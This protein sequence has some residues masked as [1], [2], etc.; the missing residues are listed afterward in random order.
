MILFAAGTLY[1]NNTD[2]DIAD[3]SQHPSVL[4]YL[5]FAAAVVVLP[6]VIG[7]GR[8]LRRGV[9]MLFIDGMERRIRFG[10]T[11][12]SA[13]TKTDYDYDFKDLAFVEVLR[14]Y[15]VRTS[16][17]PGMGVTR[18]SYELNLY[19]SP[20]DRWIGI[21]ESTDRQRILGQAKEIAKITGAKVG[22]ENAVKQRVPVN[23]AFEP[24]PPSTQEPVD[25]DLPP[26][27]FLS[28][29]DRKPVNSLEVKPGKLRLKLF[30]FRIKASD[31]FGQKLSSLLMPVVSHMVNR[32]PYAKSLAACQYLSSDRNAPAGRRNA[33]IANLVEAGWRGEDEL[34]STVFEI[35]DAQTGFAPLTR[36][37]R[38]A[39]ERYYMQLNDR[40]AVLAKKYRIVFMEYLEDAI[41]SAP[42]RMNRYDMQP[43][44]LSKLQQ[45]ENYGFK[46]V[47][48]VAAI[49]IC[50]FAIWFTRLVL[51]AGIGWKEPALVAGGVISAIATLGLIYLW[52]KYRR[53]F[54][55]RRGFRRSPQV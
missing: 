10:L 29:D 48:D 35:F 45:S 16:N 18:D 52:L 28:D 13:W 21:T 15:E 34:K 43:E 31:A 41:R 23:T 5:I 38:D 25:D 50:G 9:P 53:R 17:R 2:A 44:L 8:N 46:F 36:A 3:V 40:L 49:V 54:G 12:G 47:L 32:Q 55:K 42:D 30:P 4:T 51:R 1:F 11:R 24:A 14:N 19:F 37:S 27:P 7:F 39:F 22:E 26:L 33:L 6:F 20:D